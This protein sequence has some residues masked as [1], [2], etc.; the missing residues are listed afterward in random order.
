MLNIKEKLRDIGNNCDEIEKNFIKK[1]VRKDYLDKRKEVLQQSVEDSKSRVLELE[2][3]NVVLQKMSTQ[4]RESAKAKLEKLGTYALQYALSTDY[5]MKIYIEEIRK[6]PNAVV[7]IYNKKTGNETDPIDGNGGG[8]I[9]I[10]SMALRLITM[11]MYEPFT[12]GPLLLDEPFKMVSKEYVPML[13]EFMKKVADDFNR[14]IILVTH[15]E[16]LSQMADKRIY[17]M[18]KDDE[19]VIR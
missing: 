17:V 12:D 13:S 9:D 3:T 11:Q 8:V 5:E 4:Q 14:Q 10:V 1:S 2:Q 19:S 16:F 18:L 7:K 6:K 15:N